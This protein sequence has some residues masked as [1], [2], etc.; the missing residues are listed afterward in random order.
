LPAVTCL[1]RRDQLI[2]ITITKSRPAE[3]L[4]VRPHTFETRFRALADLST[5]E[6]GERGEGG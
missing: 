3:D 4:A 5:F 2:P 6:L 1:E